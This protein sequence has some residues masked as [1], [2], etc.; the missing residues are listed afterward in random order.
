VTSSTGQENNL[1]EVVRE[2][3]LSPV[4]NDETEHGQIKPKPTPTLH[5]C[6][7]SFHK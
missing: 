1:P 7:S 6:A 5:R 4:S 2:Q 3:E